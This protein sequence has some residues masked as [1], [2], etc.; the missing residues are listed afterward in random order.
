MEYDVGLCGVDAGPL[1]RFLAEAVGDGSQE[2]EHGTQSEYGEDV[3]EEHHVG[4]ERH[5]E[6]GRNAVECEN[7]VAELDEHHR[8]YQRSQM[9]ASL[10]ELHHRMIQGN[11]L[12]LLVPVQEHLG[13]AVNQESSE[14]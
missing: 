9:Q 11:D 12:F 1:T 13:T 10:H 8:H 2:E 6:Y 14:N 7:Q 3:G 5:G 4:I